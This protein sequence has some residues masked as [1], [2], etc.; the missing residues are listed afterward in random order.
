MGKRLAADN[1]G[2]RSCG[3]QSSKSCVSEVVDSVIILNNRL[4]VRQ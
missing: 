2:E 4:H 1:G 3:S